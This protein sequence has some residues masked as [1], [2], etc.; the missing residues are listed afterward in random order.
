MNKNNF[1]VNYISE[2]GMQNIGKP[3]YE[4]ILFYWML[5]KEK[6]FGDKDFEKLTASE[7][8]DISDGLKLDISKVK[9]LVRKM[10]FIRDVDQKKTD[11]PFNEIVYDKLSSA[12]YSKNDGLVHISI[13]NPV[14]LDIVKRYLAEN[15]EMYDTSFSSNVLKISFDALSK[16]LDKNQRAEF[17]EKIKSSLPEYEKKYSGQTEIKVMIDDLNKESLPERIITKF[18][19]V[20]NALANAGNVIIPLICHD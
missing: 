9:S 12:V 8:Y 5:K 2:R 13:E 7:L 4:Q 16:L 1:L 20:L 18:C 3:E 6:V 10:A 19:D 15:N 17:S 14:E 11:Y